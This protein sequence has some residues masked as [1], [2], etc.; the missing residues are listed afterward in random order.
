MRDRI[1]RV[2]DLIGEHGFDGLWVEPSQ[3]FTYL[4]GFESLSL[5]RLCGVLVTASGNLRAVVP[6][7]HSEEFDTLGDAEQF[8][9]SD[10][11]GP[12]EAAAAC[13]KGI[14]R[15]LVEPTLPSWALFAVR[16]ASGAEIDIDTR[17][18]Q[19]LR[20]TKD[21]GEIE[22]LRLAASVTDGVIEWIGSQIPGCRTEAELAGRIR[23]RYLELGH[24]EVIALVAS[25]PNATLPHYLGG[26]VPIDPRRPLLVDIGARIGSYWSDTTRVFFPG[27]DSSVDEAYGAVLAAYE[28]AFAAAAPGASCEAVDRAARDVLEDAGYGDYFI[29]RTGHG[30]GLDIHEPPYLRAGNPAPL[31]VGNVFTIEPGVYLPG[32]FGLRY[33]NTVYLGPDGPE[34]LN[35]TPRMHPL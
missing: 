24:S 25:G 33:E 12:D 18:L 16:S 21:D 1:K 4:F 34:A 9:W 27:F 3:N 30:L 22:Q 5:E 19:T 13:L 11:D 14:Q 20:L 6:L 15:L 2:V 28:A 32:R 10:A 29:H 35:K 8:I 26:D 7:M 17:V 23:V 31:D